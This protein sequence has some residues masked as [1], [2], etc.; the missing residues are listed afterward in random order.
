MI[1][2]YLLQVHRINPD[3]H[4]DTC[5]RYRADLSDMYRHDDTARAG[6][7]SLPTHRQ[8]LKRSFGSVCLSIWFKSWLNVLLLIVTKD[9]HVRCGFLFRC[10]TFQGFGNEMRLIDHNSSMTISIGAFNDTAH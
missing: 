6:N 1:K 2:H 10:T 8:H 9:L 3:V 4:L 5:S 7:S